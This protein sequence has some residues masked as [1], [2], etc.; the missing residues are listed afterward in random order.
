MS[1]LSEE[2]GLQK[3]T[4]HRIL[5]TLVALGYVEQEAETGRYG[6][7]LKLWE[8]GAA[9]VVEHPVKRAATSFLQGLQQETGETVSLVVLSGDDVLYLEKLISPRA[10]RFTARAGSRVPAALSAGGRAMLAY[11]DDARE[12]LHRT[13]ARLAAH[14]PLDVDAL[15]AEFEAVRRRGYSI[16]RDNPR[17]VS[18]GCALPSRTGQPTAALSVSA[19]VERLDAERERRIAE[20]LLATCAR[21]T[22]TVGLI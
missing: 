2:V 7:S 4:V 13:A 21:L 16:S 9:V 17:V 14:R 5:K 22:Q 18:M 19:P 1:R 15:I 3:G 11:R 10:V 20:S 12:V 6:L 8:L